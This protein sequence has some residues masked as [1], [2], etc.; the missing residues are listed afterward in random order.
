MAQCKIICVPGAQRET[1]RC[2]CGEGGLRDLAA[3][4][5]TR[6]PVARGPKLTGRRAS[7]A[8][9]ADERSRRWALSAKDQ[10]V[11]VDTA[12]LS[13]RWT[14][15]WG[16]CRPVGHELRG[17][18][19]DRW[20]R[21]HSLP[22]SKRCA[23]NEGEYAEL[24]RRHQTVLAELLQHGPGDG[25]EQLLVFTA[26]WTANP[27]PEEREADLNGDARCDVLDQ[28]PH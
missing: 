9:H 12:E 6:R 26:S 3:R 28:C 14:A 21:F 23:G 2:R 11:D 7:G 16:D 24:L 25:A 22:G 19:R 13:V 17:C 4:W 1:T 15:A 18:L 10:S 8:A 27:G 20:V 5:P